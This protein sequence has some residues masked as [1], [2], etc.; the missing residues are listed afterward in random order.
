MLVI[1]ESAGP[2]PGQANQSG[3]RPLAPRRATGASLPP[4]VLGPLDLVVV[5][6]G[7]S[8]P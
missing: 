1:A 3:P 8:E 6:V 2:F 4:A 5:G 7:V